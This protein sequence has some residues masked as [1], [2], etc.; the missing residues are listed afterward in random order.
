MADIATV[1]SWSPQTMENMPLAELMVWREK[2][3]ER[4][5]PVEG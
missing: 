1:F 4:A 5:T 2:A 3:V